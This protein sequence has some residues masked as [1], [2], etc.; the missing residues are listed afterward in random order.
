M[1]PAR[2]ILLLIKLGLLSC[3]FQNSF[4]EVLGQQERTGGNWLAYSE[5]EKELILSLPSLVAECKG[6]TGQGELE[7]KDWSKEDLVKR[8]GD[9]QNKS[10]RYDYQSL[11]IAY[12]LCCLN[13]EYS[14]NRQR[15][16][17]VF[18]PS[19]SNAADGAIEFVESL[20]KK[21]D[22]GLV[23][24]V[25]EVAPWSDGTLAEA[26]EDICSDELHVA[27]A[28]FLDQL[29]SCRKEVRNGFYKF[30]RGHQ[31]EESAID[32]TEVRTYLKKIPKGHRL[33]PVAKEF[34]AAMEQKDNS[35]G[36]Q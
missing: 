31:S 23:K 28:T 24:T 29:R 25:F 4:S 33:A 3:I 32:W 17:A 5:E 19:Q 9:L 15:L 22:K 7:L 36:K 2:T 16:V 30:V 21:G 8:L 13:H 12:L 11:Q 14:L 27:P 6:A 35:G 10:P 18:V 1:R 20:I 26:V 34:L